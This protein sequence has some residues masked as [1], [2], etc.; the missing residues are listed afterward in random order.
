MTSRGGDRQNKTPAELAWE[1]AHTTYIQLVQNKIDLISKKAHVDTDTPDRSDRLRGHLDI[2]KGYP[3]CN[4]CVQQVQVAHRSTVS[5]FLVHRPAV[6]TLV[7]I[8]AVCVCV[9]LILKT[10]PFVK[11]VRGPFLWDSLERGTM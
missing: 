1:R 8:A 2:E 10:P 4:R 6:L 11:Y 5:G 7:C 9:G 3:H